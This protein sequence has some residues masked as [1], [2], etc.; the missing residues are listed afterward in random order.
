MKVLITGSKGQLGHSLIKVFEGEDLYLLDLPEHNLINFWNTMEYFCKIQP[1]LVIHC[2]A[3]TQVDEC[4]LKPEEAYLANVIA[5]KNVVNACREVNASL[6][7]LSTDY[8]F[9]GKKE[10][11][12]LEYDTCNPLSVYGRTKWQGEEIVKAH[13]QSFYIVRTAWLFGD[14][15]YNFVR[16]IL[17]LSEEQEVLKIVH[18]QIGSPTYA[19]DL[20]EA[21]SKLVHT[22]AFG[23]YHVTNRGVCSW[24]EFT[25]D[26]LRLSGRN[27][28]QVLPISTAELNRPAP[29]PQNSVLS[30]DGIRLLNIDMPSYQDALE[31]FFKKNA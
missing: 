4:E 30:S 16:T 12:Y 19:W 17:K 9:D 14:T 23:I 7:Y 15:G 29:R 27:K 8:V 18:D 1:D 20:A 28:T 25:R 5:T 31:R 10:Q 13:L 24:F 11:P 3:K 26:I 22:K 6:V 21:V 2:A